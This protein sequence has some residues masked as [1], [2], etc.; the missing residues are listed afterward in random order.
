MVPVSEGLQA[1]V[2]PW[3]EDEELQAKVL[4]RARASLAG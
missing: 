3:Q 2:A 1:L 4:E